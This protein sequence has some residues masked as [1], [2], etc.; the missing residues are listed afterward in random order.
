ME[1][2]LLNQLE[3]LNNR[4][5]SGEFSRADLTQLIM[6][7]QHPDGN[8]VIRV[9][10]LVCGLSRDEILGILRCYPALPTL[11][12]YALLPF[13]VGMEFHE[14][15]KLILDELL[16]ETN[17]K[18]VTFMINCL[19]RAEYPILTLLIQYLN[20]D[21]F[22]LLHRYK[23]VLKTMGFERIRPFL[24]ALPILPYEQVFRDVFGDEAIDE[25]RRG[26]SRK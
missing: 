6:F 1:A 20:V 3:R 24:L 16:V 13:F 2:L 4:L 8:V 12:K 14:P 18:L 22:F 7:L 5:V 9:V 23:L 11:T 26:V 19:G 15:Y 25:L 21:D 17:E 10:P